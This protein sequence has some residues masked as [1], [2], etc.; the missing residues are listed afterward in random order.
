MKCAIVLLSSCVVLRVIV[1]IQFSMPFENVGFH[2]SLVALHTL[3]GST[4]VFSVLVERCITLDCT[5]AGYVEARALLQYH[6][7]PK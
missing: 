6:G 5:F 2:S 1:G 7:N 4:M 3:A